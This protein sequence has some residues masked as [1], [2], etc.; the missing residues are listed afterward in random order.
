MEGLENKM[1][2]WIYRVVGLISAE[3]SMGALICLLL[4]LF[5]LLSV[6]PI[7]LAFILVDRLHG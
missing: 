5:W 3:Y 2:M 4:G 6:L 1:D 7:V